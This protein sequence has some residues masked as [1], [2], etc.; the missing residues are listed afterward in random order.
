MNNYIIKSLFIAIAAL[1]MN[2]TIEAQVRGEKSVGANIV[3]TSPMGEFDFLGAGVKFSYN[4]NRFLRAESKFN[5]MFERNYEKMWDF[6]INM[7]F[8]IPLS[9]RFKIYPLSGMG[10]FGLNANYPIVTDEWGYT[11]GG[12]SSYHYFGLNWGAG[13]DYK[14][15]N[16][17]TFNAEGIFKM[18]AKFNDAKTFSYITAGLGYSF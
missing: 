14:I 6:N 1:T 7:N 10:V 18:E 17:I 11:Y 5:Y 2:L 4:L 3:L 15:S 16:R 12:K 13:L 9:N 8:L